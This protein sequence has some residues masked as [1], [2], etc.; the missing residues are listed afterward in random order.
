MSPL[1]LFELHTKARP[2]PSSITKLNTQGNPLPSVFYA[3]LHPPL[4]G[5][6]LCP[7]CIS[8]GRFELP[9][10]RPEASP[11]RRGYFNGDCSWQSRW[12]PGTVRSPCCTPRISHEEVGCQPEE[13]DEG[14]KTA[15]ARP[16]PSRQ[17]MVSGGHCRTTEEET[18]QSHHLSRDDL[19]VGVQ[20]RTRG[21][22]APRETPETQTTMEAE[23]LPRNTGI[24]TCTS[25]S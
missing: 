18:P 15:E 3:F 20:G 11:F 24:G 10:H 12:F 13:S 21:T 8:P 2:I 19:P 23:G 5:G 22:P 7:C 1:S 17:R 25:H 14:H 6:A 16:H 4:P 9:G